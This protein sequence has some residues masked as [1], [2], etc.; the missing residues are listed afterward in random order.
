MQ[1][2]KRICAKRTRE[3]GPD[4][5]ATVA[6]GHTYKEWSAC[7]KISI[8]RGG[9][10]SSREINYFDFEHGWTE[11]CTDYPIDPRG[12]PV[13]AAA[14]GLPPLAQKGVVAFSV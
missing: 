4:D 12:D 3:L 10:C 9:R 11:Q 6:R 7:W 5:P 1:K 14:A 2:R 13:R 8:C